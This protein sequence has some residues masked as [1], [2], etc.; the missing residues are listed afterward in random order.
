MWN[1]SKFPKTWSEICHQL[2]AGSFSPTGRVG[3]TNMFV[4]FLLH[5]I[6]MPITTSI[7]Q[8]YKKIG[9]GQSLEL[10]KIALNRSHAGSIIG[11]LRHTE[12]QTHCKAQTIDFKD[13]FELF[14]RVWNKMQGLILSWCV[15]KYWIDNLRLGIDGQ[16][17]L[18]FF[19]Q[20]KSWQIFRTP[21]NPRVNNGKP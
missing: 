7:C 9:P 19:Y 15:S 21:V 13:I 3:S 12:R 6:Y 17:E 10:I 14:S 4:L 18:F 20:N 1:A 5:S 11:P 16:L 2:V 8:L